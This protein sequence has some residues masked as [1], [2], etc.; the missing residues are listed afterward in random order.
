MT[1]LQCL[2]AVVSLIAAGLPLGYVFTR[3]L[4]LAAVLAPLVT[5]LSAA[6]ATLP[7]LLLGGQLIYWLA[8]VLLLQYALV[9]ILLARRGPGLPHG[10]GIDVFWYVVPL[11][12][13]FLLVFAPP[14]EWD[15]NSIW[16][17]HA[18]Y[19]AEGAEV[20][21]RTMGD[22]V[23]A[24]THADYPP[25]GSAAV[26][27]VWSITGYNFRVALFASSTVTFSAIAML[28]YAVR[29][30]AATGV[31]AWLSRLAGVG[32]GLAVWGQAP[33][34]PAG[35]LSDP[36]WAAS[37]VAAA[38][39]VLFRTDPFARPALPLL[40]LT[41]A[42]LTKN[43]G[44]AAVVIL[45]GLVVL[46]ERRNLGRASLMG[47]PVLAGLAW[48]AVARHLGARSDYVEGGNISELLSGDPE[49][50]ARLPPIWDALGLMLGQI[51][52]LALLVSV[53]GGVYLRSR[54]QA[55]GLGSDLWMWAVNGMFV[56]TLI[57]SY[58]I[59]GF[60]IAWH[61]Q[62]SIERVVTPVLIMA[63]VSA[64]YWGVTAMS[65]VPAS[66]GTRGDGARLRP[67]AEFVQPVPAPIVAQDV[68]TST[69]PSLGLAGHDEALDPYAGVQR[70]GPPGPGGETGPRRRL[71]VRGG[72]DHR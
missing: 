38:V 39:L 18:A 50:F 27:A 32:V 13:P 49:V 5:A 24:F 15:A 29:W 60:N 55:L 33:A 16:W 40:L 67:A 72:T 28:V 43:E 17:L 12:A 51:V 65:P 21:R 54:R 62:T 37:F 48:S 7:M 58:L 36:A 22:P 19:F 44:L 57:V 56:L 35:G 6:L 66:P 47:I 3:R 68:E 53:L 59:S 45:T 10:T 25:L 20:S 2:F 9:P 41:V 42:A 11:L 31:P 52:G 63:C 8:G 14:I 1:P 70:G 64:V 4:L 46:R 69:N 23:Y 34:S 30:V 71:P 61:L 26:A